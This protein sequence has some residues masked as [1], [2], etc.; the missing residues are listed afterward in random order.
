MKR[1]TLVHIHLFFGI[2]LLP[3]IIMFSVTSALYAWGITG[4]VEEKQYTIFLSQPLKQDPTYLHEWLEDLLEI[5]GID[6]P[7][8]RGKLELNNHDNSYRYYW[9][10]SSREVSVEPTLDPNV[11]KLVVKESGAYRYFIQ[12]LQGKGADI[13]KV[14]ITLVAFGLMFLT[15]SGLAM[16]LKVPKYRNLA[17]R[18]LLLGGAMFVITVIMS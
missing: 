12:L 14:Y 4:S 10:G 9:S 7:S 3:F 18:Y 13:F 17:K 16:A 6:S 1:S 5:K 2:L 8:G 15:L 11:A